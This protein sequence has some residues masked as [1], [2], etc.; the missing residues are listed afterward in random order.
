MTTVNNIVNNSA[1]KKFIL[2]SFL[3]INKP[4]YFFKH[5]L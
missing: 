2:L 4:L 1:N 3:L 5:Y